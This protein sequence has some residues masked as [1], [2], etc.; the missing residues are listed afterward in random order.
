MRCPDHALI[1]PLQT[2]AFIFKSPFIRPKN[3]SLIADD[4]PK[5]IEEGV[6]EVVQKSIQHLWR[7]AKIRNKPISPEK[8]K[9][10]RQGSVTSDHKQRTSR[11]SSEKIPSPSDKKRNSAE[12]VTFF[13]D[14]TK[15]EIRRD[16]KE[17]ESKV[18]VVF[19]HGLGYARQSRIS[20]QSMEKVGKK[21][22]K[23]FGDK[24]IKLIYTKLKSPVKYSFK[25]Q[26]Q[27]IYDQVKEGMIAQKLYGKE[28]KVIFVG[29]CTGALASFEA[30]QIGRKELNIVGIISTGTPW[31]G[32]ELINTWP[33]QLNP[34]LY[35]FA[36]LP[37]HIS[38]GRFRPGIKDIIP[39]S[40]YL[41][42][43]KNELKSNTDIPIWAVGG[44]TQFF[45]NLFSIP[46]IKNLFFKRSATEEKIFGALKHDGLVSLG[47][48]LGEIHKNILSI[49]LAHPSNHAKGL[50]YGVVSIIKKLAYAGNLIL[51]ES[52]MER[53]LYIE[54][55]KSTI[56]TKEFSL[57]VNL[58]IE[59]YGFNVYDKGTD[60]RRLVNELLKRCKELRN[61][62][63]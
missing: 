26:G 19:V 30:Y 5:I 62:S 24:K 43:L 55:E 28:Y 41:S 6:D 16:K 63:G 1:N 8:A 14:I 31:Q 17:L 39:G 35:L 29:L 38:Y 20:I 48:Q 18:V 2:D 57:L 36:A 56:E 60:D 51:S 37:L 44:N 54:K 45:H 4:Y 47:S 61:L 59:K 49:K 32:A 53:L 23:H 42:T 50:R 22:I 3:D 52:D 27:M 7:W 10:S 46:K 34:F 12:D 9:E 33:K 21:V 58:F 11:D 40:C 25:Q 15:Q 13:N